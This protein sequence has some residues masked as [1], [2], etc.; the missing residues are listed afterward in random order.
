MASLPDAFCAVAV[1]DAAASTVHMVKPKTAFLWFI[2]AS[3]LTPLPGVFL[4]MEAN[5]C[6][7]LC[8]APERCD[9]G[10]AHG[11]VGQEHRGRRCERG[12]RRILVP[13]EGIE[14]PTNGLQNRCS[15]PELT[16]RPVRLRKP[17]AVS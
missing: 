16:R 5:S 6:K 1:P 8:R 14:P 3:L 4:R 12:P 2:V 17:T 10:C 13:G 11:G 7:G 9:G 15:T